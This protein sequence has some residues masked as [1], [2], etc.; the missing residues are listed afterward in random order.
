MALGRV[1][2]LFFSTTRIKKIN[3]KL[4]TRFKQV[5]FH[6]TLT[7]TKHKEIYLGLYLRNYFIQTSGFLYA[8]VSGRDY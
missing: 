2:Q 6:L 5:R 8:D 4:T 1:E 3:Y 7:L